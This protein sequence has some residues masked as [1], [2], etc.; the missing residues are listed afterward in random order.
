MVEEVCR[1]DFQS[2]AD[3]FGDVD[4]TKLQP[5]AEI[6]KSVLQKLSN[7]LDNPDYDLTINTVPRG[8]EDKSYFLWH[9]EILPRLTTPAGF[10]LGIVGMRAEDDD[11]QLAVVRGSFAV[12]CAASAGS[13]TSCWRAT[14]SAT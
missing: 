2:Q 11:P 14:S 5:L 8:D 3:S 6:L 9:I 4:A 7:G 10:E 1:G 13:S 12:N